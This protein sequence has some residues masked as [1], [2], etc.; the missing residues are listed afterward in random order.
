MKNDSRSV[1]N[2]SLLALVILP[3][4]APTGA[5]ARQASIELRL[6]DPVPVSGQAT[7][8]LNYAA[9]TS[10]HEVREIFEEQAK[11]ARSEHFSSW[12]AGRCFFPDRPMLP[13]ASIVTT[14]R[15][16]DGG[17]L[18]RDET[19]VKI[20]PLIARGAPADALDRPD[21]KTNAAIRSKL[22]EYRSDVAYAVRDNASL[23]VDV[24]RSLELE[25]RQYHF[26]VWKDH[27]LL[28]MVCTESGGCLNSNFDRVLYSEDEDVAYCYFFRRTGAQRMIQKSNPDAR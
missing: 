27:L 22:D 25:A 28:K 8:A 18:F 4:F 17:P 15:S 2:L 13:V 7:R 23:R 19:H 1:W 9:R 20:V 12:R 10:Y 3:A 5:V 24:P 14:D 6:L 11:E 16:N 21:E 26:R